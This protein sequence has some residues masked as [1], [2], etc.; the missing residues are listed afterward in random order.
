MAR[1][2]KHPLYKE[3]KLPLNPAV[4]SQ[5][6]SVGSK[7]AVSPGLFLGT[8]LATLPYGLLWVIVRKLLSISQSVSK[9]HCEN[10]CINVCSSPISFFS[11]KYLPLSPHVCFPL[12]LI[13]FQVCKCHSLLI[14]TGCSSKQEPKISPS[15]TRRTKFMLMS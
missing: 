15:L 1:N 8:T 14:I 9:L 7:A 3:M 12:V 2:T 6:C 11:S 10:T 4:L 5:M 13:L